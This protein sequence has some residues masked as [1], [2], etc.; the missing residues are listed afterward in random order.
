MN[1]IAK[2]EAGVVL[3]LVVILVVGLY[4]AVKYARQE[5][6]D[7]ARRGEV[8][9]LKRALEMYFNEHEQYPLEFEVGAH[10]YKVVETDGQ[11][12]LAWY[13]R[14]ELENNAKPRADFDEEYNIYFRVVNEG[15]GTFYDVCG[16]ISTC[17]AER[18][19]E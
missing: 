17:G 10:D 7:G 12:A 5:R 19:P 3:L 16:G 2:R 13:V 14:A 11:Q 4:P 18:R 6:R 15:G 1:R 9:E 8:V